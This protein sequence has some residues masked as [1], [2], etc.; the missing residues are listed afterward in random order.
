MSVKHYY[1][2]YNITTI[3]CFFKYN[4]SGLMRSVMVVMVGG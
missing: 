4:G 3:I 1:L 2:F